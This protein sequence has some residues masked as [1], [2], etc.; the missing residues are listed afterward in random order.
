M[1]FCCHC[2]RWSVHDELE[3]F[4]VRMLLAKFSEKNQKKDQSNIIHYETTL[5][6][7]LYGER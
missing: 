4:Y 5:K 2:C 7:D 3:K 1:V 6:I